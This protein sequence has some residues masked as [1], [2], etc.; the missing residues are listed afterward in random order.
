MHLNWIG[1]S[2]ELEL[3]CFCLFDA[4]SMPKDMCSVDV[5]KLRGFS[6][7]AKFHNHRQV[8]KFTQCCY[9]IEKRIW[10]S[11][12]QKILINSKRMFNKRPLNLRYLSSTKNWNDFNAH[13]FSKISMDFL[14]HYHHLPRRF[15]LKNR[16]KV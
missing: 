8:Y 3:H 1:K 7:Y 12:V 10:F 2:S 9:F 11:G 16:G 14:F 5:M 6:V 4:Y 15:L 13:F